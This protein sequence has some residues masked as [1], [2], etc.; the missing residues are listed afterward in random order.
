MD[1]RKIEYIFLAIA[2]VLLIAACYSFFAY[3]YTETELKFDSITML[4]PSS[5]QHTVS[6]DTIEFKNDGSF[7]F[8][9]LDV[10]KTNSSN[11]NVKTL[12]KGYLNFKGG[13][14]DYLNQ[15]C[16]LVYVK[17]ADR[18]FEHHALVVPI[19]CFDKDSLTFKDNCTVWLFDGNN[20][21]FVIDSALNSK[22]VI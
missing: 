20:R 7:G 6:G 22:V 18:G 14:V 5:S 9:N 11:G 17:F 15:S 1:K 10:T 4:A 13:S 21:E 3:K 2:I 16:Y 12:L 8:Y 19:D